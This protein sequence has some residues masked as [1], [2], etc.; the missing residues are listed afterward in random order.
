MFTLARESVAYATRILILL[1]EARQN[2]T[3]AQTCLQGETAFPVSGTSLEPSEVPESSRVMGPLFCD[4]NPH[5]H[6]GRPFG[7]KVKLN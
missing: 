4:L 7:L 6:D 1:F 5:V 2:P 3:R